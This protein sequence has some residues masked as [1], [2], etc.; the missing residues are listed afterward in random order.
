M[1]I[2]VHEGLELWRPRIF[3]E[4]QAVRTG[5]YY[6]G[7]GSNTQQIANNRLYATYLAVARG[8]TVDR[9]GTTV[10]EAAAEGHLRMGIYRDDDLDA[11]PESLVLDAGAVDVS[12]TGEKA[13]SI[14]LHLP[15]GIYFLAF[16][17]DAMPKLWLNSDPRWRC[18]IGQGAAVGY[19]CNA[20]QVNSHAYGALPDPFPSGALG[21]NDEW[22]IAVRVAAAA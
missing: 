22:Q 17:S 3:N 12:T 10:Y 20:W 19:Y 7:T 6:G 18:P 14:D 9:I 11:Y 16:V 2:E 15:A 8:V 4:W 1:G 13:V 21:M 5:S